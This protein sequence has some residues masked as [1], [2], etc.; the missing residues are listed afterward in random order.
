MYVGIIM[1]LTSNSLADACGCPYWRCLLSLHA[2]DYL[3]VEELKVALAL[4]VVQSN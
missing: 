2:V 3:T 1:L 4:K